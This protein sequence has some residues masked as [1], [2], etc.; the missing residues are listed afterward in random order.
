MNGEFFDYGNEPE[1]RGGMLATDLSEGAGG[2]D[3]ECLI[4]DTSP[5]N[6]KVKGESSKRKDSGRDVSDEVQRVRKEVNEAG[7]DQ[8]RKLGLD[9][10]NKHHTPTRGESF[11]C[12]Y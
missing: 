11:I 4:S 5:E 7:Q 8:E 9:D 12:Q 6:M 10:R 3:H 1:G 2:A